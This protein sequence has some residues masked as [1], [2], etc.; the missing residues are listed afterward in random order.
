LFSLHLLF[1]PYP[2]SPKS[3]NFH[4]NPSTVGQIQFQN[5]GTDSLSFCTSQ[6]FGFL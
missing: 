5:P 6:G 3:R 4:P 1:C 2:N